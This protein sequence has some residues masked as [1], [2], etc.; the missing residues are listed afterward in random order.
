[1]SHFSG[2]LRTMGYLSMR[3]SRLGPIN[4]TD[5]RMRAEMK[6]GKQATICALTFLA[7]LSSQSESR[8]FE[9]AAKPQLEDRYP[10]RK[11]AWPK[12]VTGFS[13]VPYATLS[14][15]RPLTLD[16]YVPRTASQK[17]PIVVFVHGGSWSG[18]NPR[19]SGAFADFPRALASLA[20]EGFVVASVEYRLSGE[21]AFP[22]A[23]EDVKSAIR[24]LKEHAATYGADPERVALWGG[25]AGGHI[26]A[27]AALNCTD[28]APASKEQR[29]DACVQSAAIW[30][31]VF[32]F[33]KQATL[34]VGN[35]A[36]KRI[37]RCE[38]EC[39]SAQLAALSPDTYLTAKAPPFLLI[40]GTEDKVVPADQSRTFEA[41]LHRAR[42]G[43]QSLYIDS[44][45]HSFIGTTPEQTKI[46]SL[47]AL[48]TTFDFFHQS[49]R[50]GRQP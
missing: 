6:T 17:R 13:D 18:G 33:A 1:M 44:V 43:V 41:N 47:K 21:A 37:M 36:A 15:F 19:Q 39:S 24:Y 46:A 29:P 49:L 42:V 20:A 45:G 50:M 8:E 25:S 16:L 2:L 10:E 23:V 30:Y 22:A 48:N 4:F 9:V 11:T 31:G 5:E 34:P 14:G 7:M 27:M 35:A 12:S 3:A 26:A 38:G 32:N 40:H 28:N